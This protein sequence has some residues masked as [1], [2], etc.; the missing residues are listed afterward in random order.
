MEVGGFL[1]GGGGGLLELLA[2]CCDGFADEFRNGDDV[3]LIEAVDAKE[4]LLVRD[5]CVLV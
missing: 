4:A 3:L 1:G 2:Y 5:C